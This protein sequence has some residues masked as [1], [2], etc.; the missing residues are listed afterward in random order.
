MITPILAN[1]SNAAKLLDMKVAEFRKLVD[2]GYLPKPRHIAGIKRWNVEEFRQ[3]G[4]GDIATGMAG[5][6][7]NV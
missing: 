4:R 3:L 1:E 2:E 7:W 6:N 5:V